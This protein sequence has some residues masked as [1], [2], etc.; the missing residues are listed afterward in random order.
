MC[1]FDCFSADYL[2]M[3]LLQEFMKK[4]RTFSKKESCQ[5]KQND[6]TSV[7]IE[8]DMWAKLYLN[9][10]QVMY[11]CENMSSF[12]TKSSRQTNMVAEIFP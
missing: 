10:L 1:Q 5:S 11:A 9:I 6:T 4:V 7:D 12:Q 2:L 3:L 8:V